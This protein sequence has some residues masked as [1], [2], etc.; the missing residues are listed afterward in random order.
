[1]FVAFLK[2]VLLL[3]L[4]ACVA[5]MIA[6]FRFRRRLRRHWECRAGTSGTTSGRDQ[7]QQFHGVVA[8]TPL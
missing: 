3:W 5:G 4:V 6:A 7:W 2:V 8:A 1:M